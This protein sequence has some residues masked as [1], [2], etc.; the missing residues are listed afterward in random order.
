[1][2]GKTKLNEAQEALRVE[3]KGFWDDSPMDYFGGGLDRNFQNDE[4][5]IAYLDKIDNEFK[6]KLELYSPEWIDDEPFSNIINFKSMGGKRVL[7]IGCGLGFN[8]QQFSSHGAN[9]VSIDQTFTAAISTMKRLTIYNLKGSV[10]VANAE[11]LPFKDESFDFIWSWGVIHHTPRTDVVVE[12]IDRV[13]DQN[14]KTKVMVY[15]RTSLYHWYN[16]MFINGI[17]KGK[18]LKMS[19]QELRNWYS[20]NHCPLAQYFSRKTL[21]KYFTEFDNVR[22]NAYESREMFL[23]HF[24]WLSLF[25]KFKPVE[26]L[27]DFIIP[28]VLK[29]KFLDSFG[30]MILVSA[31][32]TIKFIPD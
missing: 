21:R 19:P 13:L 25:K 1:M 11:E 20:D 2:T 8:T 16:I 27:V 9:I 14:G 30:H 6:T 17:L 18:L 15:H 5:Y 24:T 10:V 32:K 4:D 31:K 3:S 29:R 26:K 22:F 12:E 28:D 23:A 7:E